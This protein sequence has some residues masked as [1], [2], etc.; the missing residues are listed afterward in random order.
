M[1]KN[2]NEDDRQAWL[3]NVWRSLPTN[4]RILDAGAG[5]LKNRRY[6]MHLEYVSQDF[7]QYLAGGVST[8]W[9]RGC[10]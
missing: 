8:L 10:K 1:F 7:C 6:C 3:A 9:T 4:A 2:S 5:E